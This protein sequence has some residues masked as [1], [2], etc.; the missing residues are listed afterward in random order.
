MV[1]LDAGDDQGRRRV[2]QWATFVGVGA[3]GLVATG[4]F[5]WKAFGAD[6]TTPKLMSDDEA[7]L[8]K[9]SDQRRAAS[10]AQARR[11][12]QHP[13]GD[14]SQFDEGGRFIGAAADGSGLPRNRSIEE[15]AGT[16]ASK[17]P[18]LG[19]IRREI[20]PVNVDTSTDEEGADGMDSSGR[21]PA[22]RRRGGSSSVSGGE[23]SRRED[24][25]LGRS[26]LGYSTNQAATWAVRRPGSGP[27]GTAREGG[28]GAPEGNKTGEDAVT[29]VMENALR[30]QEQLV[31]ASGGR[32]PVLVPPPN[33]AGSGVGGPG[34]SGPAQAGS[35]LYAGG[36]EEGSGRASQAFGP[37]GVGDMRVG[38]EAVSQHLVRQGKFLDCA[39]VNQLRADLVESPVIAM[40]VRDFVT[41][42]GER[43]LIP[44]GAKLLGEAGRVQN[45]QQARV[46]IRFER[47]IYPDQRAAYFPSRKAPAVD[48]LGAAGVEGDVDR[49]FF[50]Q[51]GSAVMLGVLDGL[52]AA[53]QGVANGGADPSVR[54]MVLGRTSSN[55]ATVVAG[56]LSRYGNVVPTIT[57][58]PGAKLKVFFAEDALLTP[59]RRTAR[60][61]R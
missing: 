58:E 7:R 13:L 54:D 31:T 43:V 1:K 14:A 19:A 8:Q 56:I 60:W 50:L 12:R 25:G 16:T 38:H 52:A 21:R 39:L 6:K 47:I 9:L 36:D 30:A 34:T 55:L 59:Y 27:G 44:A 23:E 45:V 26:M 51:F 3:L 57:V 5:I 42:D 41:L 35:S 4:A 29:R 49:H 33:G 37:G 20:T 18:E 15:A 61:R 46:Y 32:A 48:A 17:A 2:S 28:A 53:V 40:V 11:L 24:N 22:R 10:D